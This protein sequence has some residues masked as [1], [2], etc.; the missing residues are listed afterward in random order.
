ME[1]TGLM[2]NYSDTTVPKNYADKAYIAWA[3]RENWFNPIVVS[4][5]NDGSTY[6]MY[7]IKT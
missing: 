6:T 3:L 7:D 4:T 1:S 2:F 5:T